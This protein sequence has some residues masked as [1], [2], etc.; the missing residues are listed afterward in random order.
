MPLALV[1]PD[2]FKGTMS[3]AEVAAALAAGARAAGFRALELPIADGGEG[4][5]EALLLARGGRWEPAQVG[6]A[7][8]R[9]VMA[10]FALL[11]D[12]DAVVEVAQASG[13]WRIEPG[14]R[15][16]W[17][18][19]TRGTGELIAAAARAGARTVIV[20]AGGSATTDGGAGALAVLDGLDRRPRL[21]VACDTAV[22]LEDA[23]TVYGPQK[24]ADEATVRRLI[25][26]LDALADAAPR[27]PRGRAMTGAAGGLAGGLWAFAGAELAPGAVMVL[28]A[29]GI[30]EHLAE[31]AV[32]LTGEGRIDAQTLT[33][34]AVGELAA[35]CRRASV[36]CHA[37]VGRNALTETDRRLIGLASVAEAGT[38]AAIA[39][40][41]RALVAGTASGSVARND[42]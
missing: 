26:R 23:P 37:V 28:D 33:G 36:P 40:A 39:A 12:G 18:A 30:D 35:R 25:R 27:D 32:V 22:P 13:L 3:G 7:L 41:A 11:D 9:R 5:A 6:D 2:K 10:R 31:A 15:D 8:G 19:S 16:A 38:P 14:E 1:A 4:T 42:G 29:L 21:V 17:A 24:G 20:A 34:K